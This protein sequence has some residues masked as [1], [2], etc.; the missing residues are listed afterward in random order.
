MSRKRDNENSKREKQEQ[1]LSRREFGQLVGLAAPGAALLAAASGRLSA[2]D[3]Q[4]ANAA[5]SAQAPLPPHRAVYV[6]GIHAYA[7]KVSVKPG[8]TINFYVS[9]DNGSSPYT[10]QVFRLGTDVDTP[11]A[12]TPM[13]GTVAP[14]PIQQPI[15]PGSYVHVAN[16]LP[17]GSDLR[18]LTLECWVRPSAE[19]PRSDEFKY[20]GLITQFDYQSA[21]GYGLFLYFNQAPD[22]HA[23]RV[24]FYLGD[25][26]AYNENN[27]LQ[28]NMD[29]LGQIMHWS[30]FQ[31]HHIVATWDGTNK[32][33]YIDGVLQTPVTG[34][35]EFMGHCYPGLAP[36]RLA[37][38][39]VGGVAS[40]FLNGDLAMPVIYNRAL[41]AQEVQ[42]RYANKGMQPVVTNDVLACWPLTEE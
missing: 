14:I 33:V 12:D 10:M 40:R 21:A 41:S 4:A 7:D 32:A 17:A 11:N 1:G 31:W 23:G 19:Q 5:A 15:Y 27:L 13:S 42:D 29:F 22:A 24:A 20:T 35:V 16:G 25:G 9:S 3:V 39:G 28:V 8:E 38:C 2:G 26:V 6:D 37:A 30:G 34:A 36:L 18:A